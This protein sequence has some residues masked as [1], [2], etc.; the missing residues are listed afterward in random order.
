MNT[1]VKKR[2][3][4]ISLETVRKQSESNYLRGVRPSFFFSPPSDFIN[5][6]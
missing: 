2:G 5:L 3:H 4:Y 6:N 1:K